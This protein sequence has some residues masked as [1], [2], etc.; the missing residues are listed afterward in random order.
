MMK[1]KAGRRPAIHMI[2]S[3]AETL[4]NMAV[5]AEERIPQVSELLLE[6]IE[7]ATLYKAARI[8]AD[9]VTM[10]SHVEFVDEANGTSRTVQLVYPKDA[11]IDAGKV[12]ILTLVGA[13]LI[14]LR[15]GQSILWP[16]RDGHR[17]L[18]TI[19]RVS[20]E[21]EAA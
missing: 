13:G 1:K 14:G 2:D 20:R 17:R 10:L 18:L 21:A 6:E 8:P 9:V 3:E 11:D 4:A 12:S 19:T 5:A 16:G 7:R 15:E